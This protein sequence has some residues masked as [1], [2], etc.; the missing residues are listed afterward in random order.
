MFPEYFCSKQIDN[1]VKIRFCAKNELKFPQTKTELENLF[2]VKSLKEIK[3]I[4]TRKH[5]F[6]INSVFLAS[7]NKVII[8]VFF[9]TLFVKKPADVSESFKRKILFF[10]QIL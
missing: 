1:K 6:W 5:S 10:L 8:T 4:L 3:G 7:R 9:I 2:A